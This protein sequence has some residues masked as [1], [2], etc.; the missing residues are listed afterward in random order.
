MGIY[1]EES[2]LIT[3]TTVANNTH[4]ILKEYCEND[5]KVVSFCCFSN[6]TESE[7]V[8]Q[9]PKKR[10]SYYIGHYVYYEVDPWQNNITL[11]AG[12]CMSVGSTSYYELA[13]GTYTCEAV[14]STVNGSIQWMSIGVYASSGECRH[15]YIILYC[16]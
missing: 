8:S 9:Y 16:N 10:E 3:N 12:L 15:P 2:L 11:P 5:C 7:V 4:V 14:N 6:I 1:I 13:K